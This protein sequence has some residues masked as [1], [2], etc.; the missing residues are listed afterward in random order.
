MAHT[1]SLEFAGDELKVHATNYRFADECVNRQTDADLYKNSYMS[2]NTYGKRLRSARKAAKLTQKQLA[3]KVGLTQATIS[4]LENDEYD[5]SAKTPSIADVLGV[6]A[7]WLADGK[8]D[9]SAGTRR[10]DTYDAAIAQA[11][12]AARV[13]V[14][15]ILKADKAGEPAQTFM[16]MLRMLPDPDEPFRLED[17]AR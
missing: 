12:D 2:P 11:S 14:N 6:G 7:L 16:L 5:G 17:P 9:P 15:A 8:G 1:E 3:D 13:L 10:N 4:E